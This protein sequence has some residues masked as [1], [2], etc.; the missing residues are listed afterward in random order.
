MLG[1]KTYQ[2]IAYIRNQAMSCFLGIH[3]FTQSLSVVDNTGW[4]PS[5]YRRWKLIIR[6]WNKLIHLDN[7]D[8]P[9]NI[10]P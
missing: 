7:N 9:K 8:L 5:A 4:L 10:H 3:R 6:F 1:F 2:S